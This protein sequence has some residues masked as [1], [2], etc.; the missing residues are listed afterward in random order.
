MIY[1]FGFDIIIQM[2]FVE[3]KKHLKAGKP[4]KAYYCYGDDEYVISRAVSLISGLVSVMPEFNCVDREFTKADELIEQLMQLPVM[5]EYRVVVARGKLDTA[6]VEKYLASPNPS[7]VLVMTAYIPHDSWNKAASPDV[8]NGAEGVNCN[9]LSVRYVEPFVRSLNEKTGASMGEQAMAELYAR[10]GG[11][12][13]R[14]NSEAQKLSYLRAG[15]EISVADVRE[16]VTADV[17][18][19]VFELGDRILA[20]DPK[21]ALEI[22]DGMAKNNDLAA[23][24]TLLYNRFKRIFAASVDPDGLSDLGVKPYMATRLKS[25]GAK[26]PKAKLK[27]F[28]DML[29]DADRAYKSGAMSQYDA[30][31]R[32]V[33]VAAN[34]GAV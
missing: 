20:G 26:F 21:R 4:F 24:F 28:V 14:I 19:V 31:S 15:G 16:N 2:E 32:F 27:R 11:Y 10:C 6:T 30:L 18:F 8:P 12:M 29:A 9:R 5:S 13:T 23:A 25:E 3:L 33:A 22:V 1:P 7:T 17:E 34:G